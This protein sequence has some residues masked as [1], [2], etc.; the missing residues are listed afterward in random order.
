L[1]TVPE[2]N[3]ASWI[4]FLMDRDLLIESTRQRRCLLMNHLQ[5]LELDAAKKVE[6]ARVRLWIDE[7]D[8]R[9]AKLAADPETGSQ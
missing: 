7:L 5:E 1:N 9:L 4:N 3:D 8:L 6:P 2:A